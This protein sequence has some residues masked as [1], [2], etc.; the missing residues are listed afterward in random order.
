MQETGVRIQES[1]EKILFLPLPWG[2]RV[3]TALGERA[4]D[5]GSLLPS[6]EGMGMRA[7]HPGIQQRPFREQDS[8]FYLLFSV[9]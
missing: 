2:Y 8:E 7:V 4:F 5:S 9:F 6:G 3:H 1:A